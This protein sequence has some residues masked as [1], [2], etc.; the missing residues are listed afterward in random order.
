MGRIGR[1]LQFVR[2]SRHE[3]KISDVTVNTGGNVDITAEHYATAGDD[4][5]PLKT[6]YVA[7]NE[8]DSTG[9]Q[10]AIG[11]LDPINDPVAEEGDKRIYARNPEDGL[12]VNQCW[13]KSDGTTITSN[14]NGSMTL[15][16]DGSVVITNANGSITLNADGSIKLTTPNGD[17]D[18][19]TDGSVVFSS[20][21]NITTAGDVVTAS[22][23]SLD[24]NTHI[25]NLGVP[26][27]VSVT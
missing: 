1:L 22:G 26:T 15:N 21:A 16:P 2:T 25:G 6:D 13:L 10:D 5:H 27:S 18:F 7:L 17:N 9:R 11:Y 3:A 4:S 24:N 8:R 20:G 12:S 23:I 19:N 14:E